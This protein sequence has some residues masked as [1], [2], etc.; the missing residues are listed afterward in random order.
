MSF[1][2]STSTLIGTS[3]RFSETLRAVMITS[4]RPPELS[5]ASA[6]GA[7]WGMAAPA[8]AAATAKPM[9]DGLRSPPQDHGD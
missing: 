9:R 7:R 5:D 1:L 3:C 6:A 4:C 8:I 2:V